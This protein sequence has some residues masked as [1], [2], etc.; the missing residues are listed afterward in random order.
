MEHASWRSPSSPPARADRVPVPGGPEAI[1]PLLGLGV[2]RPDRELFLDV[3]RALLAESNPRGSWEEVPNRRAVVH[4]AGDLAEWKAT[5]GCLVT[6]S[7][8]GEAWEGSRRALE[9]LGFRFRGDGAGFE[10]EPRPEPEAHRSQTFLDVLGQ[11]AFE[12]I[13][14]LSEGEEVTVSCGDDD[15]ELPLDLEAWREILAVD[16]T[17]LSRETAFLHFVTRVSA[18]R[19]LAA[20]GSADARTREEA[21]A[22]A[23]PAGGAGGLKL[24][25]ALKPDDRAGVLT[26][27]SHV[28]GFTPFSSD[29]AKARAALVKAR[30]SGETAL[31]DATA[32]ALRKLQESTGR[33]AVVLF[34]DGADNRSRV[35]VDRVIDLA[36]ASEASVFA[37]GQEVGTAKPLVRALG[38]MTGETGGR[39]WF[40][41][42]IEV[43]SGAFRSVVVELGIQ[44][45]LTFTPQDQRPRTWH[46]IVMKV[47]KPGL[48]ARARKSLPGRLKGSAVPRLQGSKKARSKK[49]R[50]AATR[51]AS[52]NE[53][54]QGDASPRIDPPRRMDPPS[55]IRPTTVPSR[56]SVPSFST[57]PAT[58]PS[59]RI[60]PSS[61]TRPAMR[62][63]TRTEPS[64]PISP[65]REPSIRT[66]PSRSMRAQR[67]PPFR[68]ST[69]SSAART[70]GARRSRTRAAANEVLLARDFG[71]ETS[72]I[73]TPRWPWKR[74]GVRP[75][76]PSRATSPAG[77]GPVRSRSVEPHAHDCAPG[78]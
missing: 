58:V 20:L 71:M 75:A 32:V 43:L 54:Q 26:F 50:S 56:R 67:L 59:S 68:T 33:R 61:S 4:F 36:R 41:P 53:A 37:V 65:T 23:G 70:D 21:R 77:S 10:V 62:P 34:T 28:V 27:A 57:R 47:R 8:R 16:A 76:P 13:Q 60:V 9:W 15:V 7:A 11:P 55:S 78:G 46:Q 73:R 66:D 51:R 19:M 22:L 69:S 45:F 12:A 18:S 49:K 1:R 52:S 24:L 38:R 25:A 6:L 17:V 48:T 64:F 39:A 2:G 74:V 44:Y 42:T 3:D 40:I 14:R 35:A 63:S 31:Y 29:K 30:V 72:L 5:A